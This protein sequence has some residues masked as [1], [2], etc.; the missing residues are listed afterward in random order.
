MFF[1]KLNW[2]KVFSAPS[3]FYPLLW[4]FA[5][6]LRN[7][8]RSAWFP[9]GNRHFYYTNE[10][11]CTFVCLT[12]CLSVC[13]HKWNSHQLDGIA[14]H[15]IIIT[16]FSLIVVKVFKQV[17]QFKQN[18]FSF[19][20]FVF[21]PW[22]FFRCLWQFWKK[23]PWQVWKKSARDTDFSK[24]FKYQYSHDFFKSACDILSPLPRKSAHDNFLK[25]CPWKKKFPWKISKIKSQRHFQK[26]WEKK[27]HKVFSLREGCLENFI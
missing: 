13:P 1:L 21:F 25:K 15:I 26:S 18:S 10:V 14:N 23:C 7:R 16:S 12:D 3:R 6:A 9:E 5:T 4:G 20:L 2:F 17:S 27:E 19:T 24:L 22:H 11:F 8:P